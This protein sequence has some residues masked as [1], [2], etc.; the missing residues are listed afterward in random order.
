[1]LKGIA[2]RK[3][4]AN[5]DEK[6]KV[7][8]GGVII[9]NIFIILIIGFFI[10]GCGGVTQKM[11]S[12]V[13]RG[14]SKQEVASIFKSNGTTFFVGHCGGGQGE[15]IFYE[16]AGTVDAYSFLFIDNHLY[17]WKFIDNWETGSGWDCNPPPHRIYEFRDR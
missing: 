7:K 17:G 14:M 5:A 1:L 15:I 3:V 8:K 12:K 16:Q 13:E 10:V 11:L 2:Y 9:K 4:N 6:G